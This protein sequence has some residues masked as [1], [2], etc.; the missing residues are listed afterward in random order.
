[1]QVTLKFIRQWGGNDQIVWVDVARLNQSWRLDRGYYVARGSPTGTREWIIRLGFRCIPMPHIV[2]DENGIVTFTDRQS[3]ASAG[4]LF[5][6]LQFLEGN[7]FIGED[8]G[9]LEY[10][11]NPEDHGKA[12]SFVIE[13]QNRYRVSDRT[14]VERAEVSNRTLSALKNGR[15]VSESSLSKLMRAADGLRQEMHAQEGEHGEY[16]RQLRE[17]S[18]MMGGRNNIAKALE[19]TGPYLGRVLRGEKPIT[20][21]LIA[22]LNLFGV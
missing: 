7:E 6:V 1:M 11:L 22:K 2:L 12:A 9:P 8:V 17:L 10:S 20:D 16:L 14:L 21:A 3:L 13:I 15:L 19:V 4:D 5:R 18:K